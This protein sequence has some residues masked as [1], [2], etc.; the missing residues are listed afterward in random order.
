MDSVLRNLTLGPSEPSR[1]QGQP[2]A[3]RAVPTR[4]MLAS[5]PPT[6]RTCVSSSSNGRSLPPEAEALCALLARANRRIEA[7][8]RSTSRDLRVVR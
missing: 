3:Q 6:E 4:P 2:D 1:R 8:R 7:E 5:H